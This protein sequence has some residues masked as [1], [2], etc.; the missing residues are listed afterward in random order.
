MNIRLSSQFKIAVSENFL[1]FFQKLRITQVCSTKLSLSANY[2]H[3]R[4]FKGYNELKISNLCVYIYIYSVFTCTYIQLCILICSRT[5]A[6]S[7]TI[8][9]SCSF[10]HIS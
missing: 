6:V 8:L 5:S 1:K 4:I 10:L 7:T 3:P 2:Y 9:P